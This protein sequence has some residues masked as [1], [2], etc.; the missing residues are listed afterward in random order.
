[1]FGFGLVWLT[2]FCAPELCAPRRILVSK[3][4]I[5]MAF[6]MPLD[7]L[8]SELSTDLNLILIGYEI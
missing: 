5:P 1:M 7:S 8:G 6:L 2:E 4:I 3:Q